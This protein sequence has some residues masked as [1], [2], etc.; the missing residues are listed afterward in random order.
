MLPISPGIRFRGVRCCGIRS[1][2]SSPFSSVSNRLFL[3]RSI[4][5]GN[6]NCPQKPAKRGQNEEQRTQSKSKMDDN[7]SNVAVDTHVF[8]VVKVWSIKLGTAKD[9]PAA[10][11]NWLIGASLYG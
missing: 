3:R 11:Y 9:T 1:S 6:Y 7:A 4:S 10:L 2:N 5:R 8:L